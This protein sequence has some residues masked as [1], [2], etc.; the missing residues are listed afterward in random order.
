MLP[1]ESPGSF[2]RGCVPHEPHVKM[3]PLGGL[4]SYSNLTV[5]EMTNCPL[6]DVTGK[7]MSSPGLHFLVL[8]FPGLHFPAALAS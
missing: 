2:P 8:H 1:R 6:Y 4:K 5:A 3:E 7:W